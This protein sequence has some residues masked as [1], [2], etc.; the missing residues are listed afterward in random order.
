MPI[1]NT[2][3]PVPQ[4]TAYQI[5]LAEVC[6]TA[7]WQG[8]NFETDKLAEVS[9]EVL[10]N[11]FYVAFRRLV[12]T[13]ALPAMIDEPQL[14]QL[15]R[16]GKIKAM[17]RSKLPLDFQKGIDTIRNST[18]EIYRESTK[19]NSGIGRV[20]AGVKAVL[21][22]AVCWTNNP[23]ASLNGNYRVAFSTRILFFTCPEMQVF[24]YSR[25]LEKKMSLQTR[26][27]AALPKFNELLA[28]GML[29]N[30]SLLAQ[31]KLPEKS[32]MKTQT[33]NRIEKTDWWKRRVLDLALLIHYGV[34]T[35]SAVFTRKAR[36]LIRAG[37]KV[38]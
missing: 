2:P 32:A 14:R 25:A 15:I 36:A 4:F 28:E 19:K 21:D 29:V 35:P 24:N 38:V 7:L 27:Q 31:C 23:Y 33:W 13:P 9:D 34:S 16:V 5:T 3:K 22:L 26:P 8:I 30:R 17:F 37:R 10:L 20:G 11:N 1:G 6:A 18:V 12:K